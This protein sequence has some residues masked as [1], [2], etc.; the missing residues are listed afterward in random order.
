MHDHLTD[1]ASIHSQKE[2]AHHDVRNDVPPAL[3]KHHQQKALWL[4]I[5]GDMSQFDPLI[6]DMSCEMRPP[7]LIDMYWKVQVYL[8]KENRLNDALAIAHEYQIAHQNDTD[9]VK[10][11]A[12]A[13]LENQNH[14]EAFDDLFAELVNILGDVHTKLLGLCYALTVSNFHA[15]DEFGSIFY[16]SCTSVFAH[17]QLPML[18]HELATTCVDYFRNVVIKTLGS[19]ELDEAA[20]KMVSCMPQQRPDAGAIPVTYSV[21]RY[22]AVPAPHW[23]LN[24][25]DGPPNRNRSLQLTWIDL[26]TERRTRLV[27]CA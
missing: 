20:Q 12:L 4:L 26:H 16:F 22:P 15:R 21:P 1:S 13:P 14:P 17:D 5:T 3:V 18:R 25:C 8:K 2:C 10:T 23:T 6:G 24:D 19:P 27:L 9:S 7:F 11:P